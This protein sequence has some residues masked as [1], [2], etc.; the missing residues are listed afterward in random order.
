MSQVYGGLIDKKKLID[1]EEMFT[2]ECAT[3]KVLPAGGL[4]W[5]LEQSSGARRELC[6]QLTHLRWKIAVSS[7]I[8]SNNPRREI[9][10]AFLRVMNVLV[11]RHTGCPVISF[12]VKL[13]FVRLTF[14]YVVARDCERVYS[15]NIPQAFARRGLL[16]DTKRWIN[17]QN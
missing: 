7:W 3:T 1:N 11:V 13:L 10:F 4:D 2:Y 5:N 8:S 14:N 6:L 17:E 15:F 12:L 16:I 9:D